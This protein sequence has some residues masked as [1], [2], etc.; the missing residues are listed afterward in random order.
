ME[1][2]GMKKF[3]ILLIG[4]IALSGC[5]QDYVRDYDSDGVFFAYQY[6]LRTFVIGEGA[7]FDVTVAL[8]GVMQNGRDRAVKLSI[9][10]SLVNGDAYRGMMGSDGVSG[11]YVAA[12]FRSAGVSSLEPL[13]PGDFTVTGMEGLKI[14]A[15]RHTGTVT[16][17][18]TDALFAD[19]NAYK[20]G[21]AIGVKIVSADADEVV[22]GLDFEVIAVRCENQFFGNWTHHGT[23]T[24]F[25]ESG[26]QVQK[27][28]VVGTLADDSVYLLV[29]E[30]A[31]TLTC[32]KMTGVAGGMRLSF[33]GND[34]TVS[35]MNGSI[36]GSG[37]FNGAKLLQDRELYLEYDT[38]YGSG[39]RMNVRDTLCFR[40]RIRDG[41]NEWQDENQEHYR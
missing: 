7:S 29:T 2:T 9:D 33:S 6:D 39:G 37:R 27:N 20:P 13:P 30:D 22:E 11:D 10:N 28:R 19:P 12:A 14:P 36:T 5:Y 24:V 26:K 31:S 8:G 21:Y 25:D 16:V 34:I 15:G 18:A 35:S 3:S 41:V 32:S 17:R 40:N 38:P 4:A 1:I 23:L